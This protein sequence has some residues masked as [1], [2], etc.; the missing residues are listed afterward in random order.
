MLHLGFHLHSV[1]LTCFFH[2]FCFCLFLYQAWVHPLSPSTSNLVKLC[3]MALSFYLA[4]PCLWQDLRWPVLTSTMHRP[5]TVLCG[6][7]NEWASVSLVKE[8]GEGLCWFSCPSLHSPVVFFFWSS[9]LLWGNNPPH[10][11]SNVKLVN[12]DQ[13]RG[14]NPSHITEISGGKESWAEELSTENS[15]RPFPLVVVP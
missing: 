6:Y 8:I 10:R 5:S 4:G 9:F 15:S 2:S 3:W 14:P 7:W 11:Y 13:G 12:Q 1:F